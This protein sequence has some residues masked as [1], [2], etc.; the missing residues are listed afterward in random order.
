MTDDTRRSWTV[1]RRA[2]AA[3]VVAVLVVAA[4]GCANYTQPLETAPP[5]PNHPTEVTEELQRLPPPQEKVVAAVYRFRDQ[6]GQHKPSQG[7]AT[8]FSTAV[9][10][11]ATS[12]LIGAL[13]DSDWFVPIERAGLSNLLNERQ[14]IQQIRQQYEDPAETGRQGAGR[15]PPM[16]FA[17]VILEGG[18]IGYNTNTMT[19]GQAARY[20]G[21]GGSTQ[22]RQDQVTVYLRAVSTKTG[23]ILKNV[24]ATKTI[25]SQEMEAGIFR[26]VESDRLLQANI[27][28]SYNEPTTVAVREAI[29]ESVKALVVEGVEDGLW[30][31]RDST[32]I[33]HPVLQAYR[34]S[35]ERAEEI[36]RFDRFAGHDRS[37]FAVRASLGG[38]RLEGNF[39]DALVRASGGLSIRHMISSRVGIGVGGTVGEIAA[40][41]A[42]KTTGA[43][44]EVQGIYHFL[45][46]GTASPY[47]QVGGGVLDGDLISGRSASGED[48][49]LVPYATVGG[50]IEYLVGPSLGLDV[51]LENQYALEEGIDDVDEGDPNDSIWRLTAGLTLYLSKF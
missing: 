12:I 33:D 40:E 36:D 45:P 31:L 14:I 43:S 18:I 9:T 2:L 24:H 20:F 19:G 27:G 5:R 6:T 42:F 3:C 26:F 10:Q 25:I 35:R 28:Y 38:Q 13:E 46:N 8:S 1:T 41:N 17:G 47:L 7:G 34:E 11:G 22:F 49:P 50:G 23:R 37:G 21:A 44:A 39:G 29:E 30:S 48:L 32:D 16:L 15:L 4:A 51:Q